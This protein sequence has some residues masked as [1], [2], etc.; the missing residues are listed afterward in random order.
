MFNKLLKMSLMVMAIFAMSVSV[1]VCDECY[2]AEECETSLN[3]DHLSTSESVSEECETSLNFDHLGTSETVS[4]I[5][6][7]IIILMYMIILGIV[8][9]LFSLYT[10]RGNIFTTRAKLTK[11]IESLA[12]DNAG[13]QKS[14]KEL[15]NDQNTDGYEVKIERLERQITSTTQK[16]RNMMWMRDYVIWFKDI[17]FIEDTQDYQSCVIQIIKKH[18]IQC[19]LNV[20]G[21]GCDWLFTTEVKVWNTALVTS[22]CKKYG[23]DPWQI[24]IIYDTDTPTDKLNKATIGD[25]VKFLNS[26]GCPVVANCADFAAETKKY[27]VHWLW[28]FHFIET[29]LIN[30]SEFDDNGNSKYVGGPVTNRKPVQFEINSDMIPTY[31]IPEGG[32]GGVV[33]EITLILEHGMEMC[34]RETTKMGTDGNTFQTSVCNALTKCSGSCGNFVN[35]K[36]GP[37]CVMCQ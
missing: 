24:L 19:V 36:F 3:F 4:V 27:T 5:D 12:R 14:S 6:E 34:A 20:S 10:R 23:C 21:C 15:R 26:L 30:T 33:K 11:H 13:F 9:F 25:G 29:I 28:V 32:G 31:F 16:I 17:R 18:N 7:T 37:T 22:V 35:D 1:S 2:V 8:V